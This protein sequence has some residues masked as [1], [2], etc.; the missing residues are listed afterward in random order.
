[1]FRALGRVIWF[2]IQGFRRHIWLSLVAVFTMSL[3]LTAIMLFMLVNIGLRQAYNQVNQK[4]NYVIFLR[5]EASEADIQS[6]KSQL[7][8]RP[9]V[10]GVSYKDKEAVREDFAKKFES[11]DSLKNLVTAGDNPLPRQLEISFASVEQI[12]D[13]STFVRQDRFKAIV[14]NDSYLDTAQPIQNYFTFS[15]TVQLLTLTFTAFLVLVAIIV[16]LNTVRLAVYSRR[17]EIEVM[18]LVG[19]TQQYIRGPFLVEGLLYGLLGALIVPFTHE[20]I[21]GL[22]GES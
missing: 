20:L 17:E 12:K 1:M 2:G 14:E 18:R 7:Q 16:I 5:D 15:R 3:M 13:F 11:S 4:I 9:E 6:F 8:N 19:A 10:A 22:N 21:D